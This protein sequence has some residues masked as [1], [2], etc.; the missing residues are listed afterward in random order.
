MK[1]ILKGIEKMK[2]KEL[3]SKVISE[4]FSLSLGGKIELKKGSFK[5]SFFYY[6]Y[7]YELKEFKNVFY[8]DDLNLEDKEY[9]L[10]DLKIDSIENFRSTINGLGINEIQ[11]IFEISEDEKRRFTIESI[12]KQSSTIFKKGFNGSNPILISGAL[13]VKDS[14]ETN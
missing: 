14:E 9:F 2:N 6:C 12:N 10:N 7:V 8:I 1:T 4:N 5:S 13:T 3:K 11:N